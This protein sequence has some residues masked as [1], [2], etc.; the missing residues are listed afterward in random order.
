MRSWY[1]RGSWLFKGKYICLSLSF[2]GHIRRTLCWVTKS[3]LQTP[4]CFTKKNPRAMGE[5]TQT[6]SIRIFRNSGICFN[7]AGSVHI[8]VWKLLTPEDPMSSLPTGMW[9]VCSRRGRETQDIEMSWRSDEQ[10]WSI[11]LLSAK[12]GY[13]EIFKG[14]NNSTCPTPT[15]DILRIKSHDGLLDVSERWTQ[16]CSWL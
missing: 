11:T 5:E 1:W 14:Q 2:V 3:Y 12:S 16:T 7:K 4:G 9:S 10:T 15:L 13:P 6:W 8:Q